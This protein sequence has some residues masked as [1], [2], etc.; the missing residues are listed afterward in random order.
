M[1]HVQLD[2][3]VLKHVVLFGSYGLRLGH[4]AINSK[5]TLTGI[6]LPLQRCDA[7][8]YF[9]SFSLCFQNADFDHGKNGLT[10]VCS[11]TGTS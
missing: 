3:C 7:F 5:L 6:L 8:L 2:D 10:T 11:L 4:V 1:L 9:T